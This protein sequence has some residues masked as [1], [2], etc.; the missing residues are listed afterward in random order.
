VAADKDARDLARRKVAAIGPVTAQALRQRRDQPGRLRKGRDERLPRQVLRELAKT[1]E[2]PAMK[3]IVYHTY[4][5][6]D[7]L[8][9][10]DTEKPTAGLDR[11]SLCV[12]KYLSEQGWPAGWPAAPERRRR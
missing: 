6:P 12:V 3:A 7:V 11:G 1:P 4:G 10:E 9:C 2:E 5:S 8:R